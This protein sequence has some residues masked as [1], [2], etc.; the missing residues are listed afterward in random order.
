[1]FNRI[2]SPCGGD[3][4]YYNLETER[5]SICVG[6]YHYS[7]GR[8]CYVNSCLGREPPCY[9]AD[10]KTACVALP[11]G[12][13]GTVCPSNYGV[14]NSD[15]TCKLQICVNRVEENGGIIHF[16]FSLFFFFF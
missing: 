2:G 7:D 14:D 16:C 4:C 15:Y 11:N 10:E 8:N 3:G 5:C 1:L 9:L 13:C 6:P 12:G